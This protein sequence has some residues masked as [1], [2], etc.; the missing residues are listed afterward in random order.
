MSLTRHGLH[1]N[2]RL[3]MFDPIVPER[4]IGRGLRAHFKRWGWIVLLLILAGCLASPR[5]STPIPSA[6]APAATV[7]PSTRTPTPASATIIP[8]HPQALG[9][10]PATTET[11]TALNTSTPTCQAQSGQL[12]IEYL[13]STVFARRV[14][15]SLYLPPCYDANSMRLYPVL[16]LL[17]GANTD[18][19]QWP[20]LHVE[21]DADALIAQGA[22]GPLLVVMPDGN[23]GT[24][25]AYGA[26]VLRDLIPH[27]E[28]TW[29]ASPTRRDRAIGGL[30][31]GGYWA[32]ELALSHPDLFSAVGG[33]SPATDS[34]LLDLL[35]SNAPDLNS[36]RIY[37]DVGNDD[38][39]ASSTVAFA[40][41]LRSHGLTPIF[42]I[43]PGEHNRPYWRSH[44]P[45]Y[46]TFYA[47][48]WKQ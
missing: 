12:R 39:L 33:H 35:A 10:T 38:P 42:H 1:H 3:R 14:P 7:H 8:F 34:A 48:P 26:F 6:S 4:G 19:T 32:L 41:A 5:A 28:Q 37:L 13:N 2:Y 11:R 47:A 25:G 31:Q 45:E 18:H 29:R 21:P 27:I 44:T 24:G 16:Y 46:L 40:T 36:L 15:Y 20:D 43:Y 22:I 17:H 30:S 9:P 23:I